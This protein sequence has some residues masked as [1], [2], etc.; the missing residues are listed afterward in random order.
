MTDRYQQLVQTPIGRRLVKQL[1]LPNPIPL[2]RYEPG[3]PVVSGP[4]LVGGAPGGR[5]TSTVM[6]VLAEIGARAHTADRWELRQ[7]AASAGL[8]AKIWN[9]EA[10]GDYRF[11]ALIFDAT[12]ID[13]PGELAEVHTFFHPSIRRV[14]PSGRII[15]L[16]VA[17]EECETVRQASAQRALE[18]F[19]RSAGKEVGRGSTTQLVYV[20]RGAES[21]VESTLRFLLS[22]KSAYVS[23][24]AIRIGPSEPGPQV[25][26][27]APLGGTVAMVTGASRGI[28]EATARTLARDGAH[29]VGVDVPAAADDLHAVTGDIGGSARTLDITDADAPAQ[30]A[31][32]MSQQHGGV[33]IVVHNA[34]INRDKTLGKM[35]EDQWRSVLDVN[36]IA[37]ERIT[38]ELLDQK[39]IRENGRVVCVSSLGGIAGNVGQTNYATS[40]AGLI[41]LVQ[42]TAPV[43]AQQ[44][45]TVNAVAPGFIETAM[46]ATMPVVPREFGRRLNSMS[47][48]GAPRDA[49]ETI[50]WFANPASAGVHGNVVRVCGQSL[51][52]A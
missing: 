40:K 44:R 9:P 8:D 14:R 1:G 35:A 45:V 37:P 13:T 52:G 51:L 24:Q 2:Q 41:G 19:T 22:A 26:W 50:A 36:L 39:L 4:V 10:G 34:G 23:G 33:D 29:V 11:A 12:A 46:T 21:R 43:A 6:R 25:D 20:S 32:H 3:M 30:L 47:Q 7:S 15:V 31:E 28:G 38:A 18:G 49:A 48:G 17:P 42:A 27:N 5:L 16:G